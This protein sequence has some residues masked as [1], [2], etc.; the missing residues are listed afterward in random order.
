MVLTAKAFITLTKSITP[1][2]AGYSSKTTVQ[3]LAVV[4]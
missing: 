4:I 3:Q 1:F 2:E